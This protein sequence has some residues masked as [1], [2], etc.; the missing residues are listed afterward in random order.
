L[1]FIIL[2]SAF[3][4][5]YSVGDQPIANAAPDRFLDLLYFSME[6]ARDGG[7]RR[8]AS[9]DRLRAPGRDRGDFHWH[10]IPCGNDGIGLCAFLAPQGSLRLRSTPVV[11]LHDGQ[12]TLMIRVANARLN[13]VSGAIARL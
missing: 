13:I 8:H 7:I 11:T 3:A 2:N 12:P 10:V 4:L 5:I 6:N 9:A 1:I